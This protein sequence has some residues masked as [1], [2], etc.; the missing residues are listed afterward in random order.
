MAKL[1]DLSPGGGMGIGNDA[2]LAFIDEINAMRAR[3]GNRYRFEPHM[4][5]GRDVLMMREV[6]GIPRPNRSDTPSPRYFGAPRLEP[7]R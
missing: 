2:L 3:A 6:L 7:V 4:D 5:K 1:I